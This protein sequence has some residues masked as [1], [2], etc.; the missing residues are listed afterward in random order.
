MIKEMKKSRTPLVGISQIGIAIPRHFI[1]L[2]ELAKK[3]KISPKYAIEGLGILQARISYQTSIED[4]AVKAISKID[5]QDVQRFYIGTESDF[6]ASKPF[7]IKILS[8]KLGLTII[9]FQYKF[10]C[11][12]GLL[13]LVSAC[14]YC[15]ANNGKPAIALAVDRSIYRETEPQAEITQGCAA[16]AMRVE[17]N[18]KLLFLDYQNFGQYGEDI[19]DFKVPFSPFPFPEING[20]LTKSAYLGCQ[21]MALE[22]WKKQNFEFLK[23]KGKSLLEFFDF[24]IVHSPFPKMVE[25]AAAMF[26]RHEIIKTK[27]HLTLA[28][29]IKT[30]SLFKEYKKE[31][32]GIRKLPDFQKFFSKKFKPGLKY[33]SFIGNA[34]TA[35]IFISLISTLERAKRNQEIGINGY[36]S[37]AGS[38]CL[39][40]ISVIKR[41]FKSDLEKQLKEGRKLTIKEYEK[42]RKNYDFSHP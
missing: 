23:S 1:S 18:P 9:P 22:D 5:F 26:W 14:E 32:D 16:V 29:C 4:L 25:W 37:G 31:L 8:Q 34:Y 42:W 41:K 21:K 3:R 15:L 40:A 6:D 28:D 10:A 30:P 12:S 35:S 39:R 36:G 24:F 2:E 20:E 13:A 11:L 19:N 27:E 33:N 7:S 38:L 17:M